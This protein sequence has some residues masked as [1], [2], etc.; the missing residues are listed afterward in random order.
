MN[1]LYL[2]LGRAKLE[3]FWINQICCRL[4]HSIKEFQQFHSENSPD[5]ECLV[6][7]MQ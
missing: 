2:N 7:G 1:T 6:P 3:I 5:P 4:K